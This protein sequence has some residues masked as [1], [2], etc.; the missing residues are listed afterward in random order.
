[1]TLH[2][3]ITPFKLFIFKHLCIW[4]DGQN[5]IGK[6][7]LWKNHNMSPN[8]PSTVTCSKYVNN[9][10]NQTRSCQMLLPFKGFNGPCIKLD[11]FILP[12]K[13]IWAKKIAISIQIKPWFVAINTIKCT[14]LLTLAFW[15]LVFWIVV[16]QSIHKLTKVW[17]FTLIQ[18]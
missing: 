12:L 6:F 3:M 1:M 14:L 2:T 8:W 18:M 16:F 10:M 17:T 4:N 5:V 11:S 15:T 9:H 7:F 13:T